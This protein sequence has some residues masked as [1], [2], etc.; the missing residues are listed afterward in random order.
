MIVGASAAGVAA[1][2]GLRTAG[3]DGRV[4]LLGAEQQMPYD[5]PPL[6]KQVLLGLWSE[7]RVTLRQRG[8]Y[9]RLRIQVRLGT[10]AAGLDPERRLVWTETGDEL[11]YT[12]LIIT[13]GSTPRRLGMDRGL[14]GVHVLRT[15]DDAV[16]LRQE[17][18]MAERVVVIGAGVLGCEV[19]AAAR[20]SGAEVV[21]VGADDTPMIKQV[22]P[23]VAE[24]L[25]ELHE[26]NGVRLRMRHTSEAVL[27]AQGRVRGVRLSD[28]TEIPAD[29]VVAAIGCDPTVDWL[30]SSGLDLSDGITCDAYCRVTDSVYAAGDVANW[31]N[32]RFGRRMRIEHRLNATEQ[33]A[34]AARNLVRGPTAFTPVPYFWSDQFG[35]RFQVYG[36]VGARAT[37]YLAEG[38]I[39]EG[40]FVV[41]Y[42]EAGR[43]VAAVGCNAPKLMLGYRRQI[44]D[45]WPTALDAAGRA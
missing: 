15:L 44:M 38:R 26:S 41:G 24:A 42:K 1:A 27:G 10:P 19:A 14:K 35:R 5:R 17:L 32:Q 9:T 16:A 31:F 36:I 29:L 12:G 6:S 3:Y 21:L 25:A 28:G 7:D 13:T 18:G 33:G 2:E 39:D 40:R 34:A 37:G 4:T 45:D 43:L 8:V 30:S 11:A 22:G 23:M 20:A